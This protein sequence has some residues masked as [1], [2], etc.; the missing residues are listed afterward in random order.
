[1]DWKKLS[2]TENDFHLFNDIMHWWLSTKGK[3]MA[4]YVFTNLIH[5]KQHLLKQ[6][7]Q[8]IKKLLLAIYSQT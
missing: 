5:L 7:E 2:M 6:Q 1:M 8:N 4:K 3:L